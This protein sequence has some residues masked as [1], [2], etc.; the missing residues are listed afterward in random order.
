MRNML[1]RFFWASVLVAVASVLAPAQQPATPERAANLRRL[2]AS[3]A[4]DQGS[5]AFWQAIGDTTLE[6]LI[7][8][9]LDG[10]HD[11]RVADARVSGARA[12][13]LN[14]ALDLTPAITAT[15]GYT[16]Q[17]IASPMV[18]GAIGSLPDQDLWDAGL[19]MSWEVDVFGR[20]RRSLQGHGELVAASYEDRRDVEI[21]LAAE[22]AAAYFDLRGAQ[23]RLAV[24]ERNAENQRGTL[25]ITLQRLEAGRGTALDSERARAQLSATL[26]DI[27]ALQAAIATAEYRLGVL[28]ARSPE[29]LAP[30]LGGATM[31]TVLPEA[32]AIDGTESF[33]FK[34]PDVRS[35][36]RQVA[37]RSAFV[38]AA[39]AEY[40][41]RVA[42]GGGAGYTSS[43]FDALGNGGTPRYTIGP[44]IS[45]PALDFARVKAGVDAARAGES[46]AKAR[47]EQ[48]LL[49]AR[50]EIETA[51]VTYR[52]ARERLHHLEESAAASERAAELA[53]LRYTE[54]ASDFLQVLDAERTLLEAQDRRALGRTNATTGL[55]SVYRALGGGWPTPPAGR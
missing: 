27:P 42:I 22:I 30:E 37:A 31:P 33:V 29:A 36:E 43:S 46:E 44:V 52:R 41:P 1:R 35:A 25:E 34:R 40:L 5:L 15:S 23:D 24:A 49:R 11:V 9:G 47:Y 16:R 55:V 50:G 20:A 3:A 39:K 48:T 21:L 7:A 53:R 4:G 38:G 2:T 13:R 32:L 6:R 12:A 17:R 10:N 54:G 14:S 18:P 45:W 28:T 51:L 8:D 26:A 19:R